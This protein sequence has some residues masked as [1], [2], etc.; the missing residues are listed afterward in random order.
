MDRVA[1]HSKSPFQD[2][3]RNLPSEGPSA[4]IQNTDPGKVGMRFRE[5]TW[6]RSQIMTSWA[7]DA[8]QIL[9][10]MTEDV[11]GGAA[12]VPQDFL[13]LFR[14][15]R[16]CHGQAAGVRPKENV[17]LVLVQKLEYVRSGRAD[18]TVVVMP[19]QPDGS[20]RT[21]P[22]SN[23]ALSIDIRLPEANALERLLALRAEPAGQGNG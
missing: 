16:Y 23:A 20:F 1:S 2:S 19:N 10:T 11:I 6:E 14:S 8:D 5:S 15:L 3:T 9:P 12:M 18:L 13:V 4:R 21:V 7:G 17:N 22:D